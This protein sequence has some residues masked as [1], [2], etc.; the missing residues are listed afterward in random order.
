MDS[1]VCMY[2]HTYVHTYSETSL[3]RCPLELKNMVELGGCR[4]REVILY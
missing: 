2:I 4:I 3:I 1:Y